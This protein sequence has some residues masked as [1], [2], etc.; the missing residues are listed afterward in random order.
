MLSSH[1]GFFHRKPF[2]KE[3]LHIE[4]CRKERFH[5]ERFHIERFHKE[6]FHI[7]FVHIELFHIECV[8]LGLFHLTNFHKERFHIEHVLDNSGEHY[9]SDVSNLCLAASSF[10]KASLT[11][12]SLR[13]LVTLM[14]FCPKGVPWV[15]GQIQRRKN[16]SLVPFLPCFYLFLCFHLTHIELQL[17]SSSGLVCVSRLSYPQRLGT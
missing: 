9:P 8:L 16:L 4:R 3:H 14:Y 15:K 17:W 1:T 5:I 2:H 13:Q 7:E 11:S 12:S 6:R 10:L